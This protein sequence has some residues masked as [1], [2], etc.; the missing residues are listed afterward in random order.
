MK[1]SYFTKIKPLDYVIII[2]ILI[3]SLGL[4]FFF[5]RSGQ[6]I[7]IRVKVTDKDVLYSKNNPSPWFAERFQEGD[8]EYDSL[9]KVISK[10]LRVD[11]LD[12]S[13]SQY[14]LQENV[15]LT[16]QTKATYDTRTK[17]YSLK[18]QKLVFGSPVRFIFSKVQFDGIVTDV[19]EIPHFYTSK[20]LTVDA[21]FRDASRS[22]ADT[23]GVPDYIASALKEGDEIRDSNGEVI[24]KILKI[25]KGPARR[26]ITNGRQIINAFDPNLYDVSYTLQIKTKLIDQQ[27]YYSDTIPIKIGN[28]LHLNFNN[29]YVW[30]TITKIYS[31]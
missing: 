23:Y 29:V 15:Y 8:V 14:N 10:I 17:S 18:N 3:A 16:I 25:N 4:L 1:K 13:E 11:K 22:Y 12:M 28:V 24:V 21:S 9:G 7:T 20:T 31:E 30:P 19:E 6:T 27:P 5:F 26:T 2:A